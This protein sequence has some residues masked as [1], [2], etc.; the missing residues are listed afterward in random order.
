MANNKLMSRYKKECQI[1][2]SRYYR[3]ELTSITSPWLASHH[4]VRRSQG[5]DESRENI[6][7]MDY[8]IHEMFHAGYSNFA[9]HLE[10][11]GF[12]NSAELWRK[13]GGSEKALIAES[14]FL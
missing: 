2:D 9:K 6:L 4:I 1:D 8:T 14:I 10:S 12:D 7:C 13:C 11:L 5:G 3:C